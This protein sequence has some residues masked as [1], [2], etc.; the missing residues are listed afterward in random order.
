[1]NKEIGVITNREINPCRPVKNRYC[2]QCCPSGS[3]NLEETGC[4]NHSGSSAGR[5]PKRSVCQD[6]CWDGLFLDGRPIETEAFS[7]NLND[8]LKKQPPGQFWMGDFLKEYLYYFP[9]IIQAGKR[10]F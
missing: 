4:G 2:I 7:G 1:M 6:N 3:P 8:W 9:D 10:L 5:L